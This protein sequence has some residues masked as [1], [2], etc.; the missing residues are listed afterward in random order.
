[1]KSEYYLPIINTID[2]RWLESNPHPFNSLACALTTETLGKI[3]YFNKVADWSN[4][5]EMQKE[6]SLL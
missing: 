2:Y 6:S 3:L 4:Q 5:F 1:M